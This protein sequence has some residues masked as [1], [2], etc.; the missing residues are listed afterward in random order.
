MVLLSSP[1]TTS[2]KEIALTYSIREIKF[3]LIWHTKMQEN[4]NNRHL[5]LG[6]RNEGTGAPAP[7]YDG[8]PNPL[9][10]VLVIPTLWNK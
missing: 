1:P 7:G 8:K 2:P 3:R 6:F 4:H 5:L 10:A 9:H